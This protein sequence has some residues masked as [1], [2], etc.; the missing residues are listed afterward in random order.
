MNVS[1]WIKLPKNPKQRKAHKVAMLQIRP[2]QTFPH[3]GLH[4]TDIFTGKV[5]R[6]GH[7]KQIALFVL[8]K[9]VY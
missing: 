6:Q 2:V 9:F 8:R 3:L 4:F 5:A 7:P 1:N